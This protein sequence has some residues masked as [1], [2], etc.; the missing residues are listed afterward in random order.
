MDAQKGAIGRVI[1][2]IDW[3]K[4]KSYHKKL[5]ILWE[6]TVDKET[7]QRV[8]NVPELREELRSLL[9]HVIE[10]NLSY[11]SH[12]SWVIFWDREEGDIGNIRVIFRLA[13]FLFE[14]HRQGQE[15]LEEALRKAIEKEDYEYAA[16]IRDSLQKNEVKTRAKY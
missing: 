1:G 11:I 10:E 6:Y 13:D 12:G 8:P 7:F 14:E 5:G 3:R 15:S 2:S 16:V 9:S 4:I